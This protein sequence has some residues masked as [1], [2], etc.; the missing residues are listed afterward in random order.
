MRLLILLFAVSLL[1]GCGYSAKELYP[2]QYHTVAVPNFENRT[3]YQGVEFELREAIIK[4]I[5]QRTPYKVVRTEGAADTLLEGVVVTIDSDSVSRTDQGGVPQEIEL[6]VTVDFTWRDLRTG[7]IL[8]GY[9]GFAAAGQYVPL[10]GVGEFYQTAQ[11][12]AVQRLA[13][14]IVSTM[15]DDAW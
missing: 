10:R 15:R 1:T 7:Q 9:E 2:T 11:H 6:T 5:E 13:E 4:E 8:R 12:R 14:D 3:F